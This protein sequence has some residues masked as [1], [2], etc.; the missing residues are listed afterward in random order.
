[1]NFKGLIFRSL[2]FSPPRYSSGAFAGLCGAVGG[3]ARAEQRD[4]SGSSFSL[5]GRWPFLIQTEWP[6]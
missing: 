5:Y 3:G 2:F 4:P 6:V 1:M